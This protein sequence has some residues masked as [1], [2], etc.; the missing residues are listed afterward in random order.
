MIIRE[1]RAKPG[2]QLSYTAKGAESDPRVFRS[3]YGTPSDVP[4]RPY[5][6]QPWLIEEIRKVKN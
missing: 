2:V 1:T 3:R 6:S 4:S 5:Y